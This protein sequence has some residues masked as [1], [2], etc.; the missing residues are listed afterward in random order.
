MKC[1]HCEGRMEIPDYAF[2]NAETY[3]KSCVVVT[4]CCDKAVII[5]PKISFRVD[6]YN[7]AATEDEW[8]TP[9]RQE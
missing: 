9:I 6:P 2:G 3:L 5:V 4:G 8:G 7:G 1:P